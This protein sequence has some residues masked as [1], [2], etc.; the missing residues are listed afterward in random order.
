[1]KNKKQKKL[2]PKPKLQILKIVKTQMKKLEFLV[3]WV[4]T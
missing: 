3:T 2:D 4:W 1:L